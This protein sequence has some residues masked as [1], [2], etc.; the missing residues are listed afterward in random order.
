[1]VDDCV[2]VVR[3]GVVVADWFDCVLV[4]DDV[5]DWF[6]GVLV[7]DGVVDRV[8][9][10]VTVWAGVVVTVVDWFDDVLVDDGVVD[11]VLGLTGVLGCT[12]YLGLVGEL[13]GLV[14]E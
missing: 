12:T 10:V 1:M 6:D 14:G 8:D 11:W 4:D 9:G 13:L 2:L 3:A 5:A 7:D